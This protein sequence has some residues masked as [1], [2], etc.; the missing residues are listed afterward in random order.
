MYITDV[1]T[2]SRLLIIGGGQYLPPVLQNMCK[3]SRGQ[4]ENLHM[5]RFL[6]SIALGLYL[7][8]NVVGFLKQFLLIFRKERVFSEAKSSSSDSSVHSRKHMENTH[9]NVRQWFE[10]KVDV[11]IEV[12]GQLKYF[13]KF[14]HFRK[15]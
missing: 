11:I 7:L 3:I 10:A 6:V 14:S 2:S 5:L 9:I 4:E 8:S 13:L 12:D 15:N 1:S